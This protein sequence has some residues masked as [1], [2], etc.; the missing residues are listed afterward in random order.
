MLK[1]RQGTVRVGNELVSDWS[2][3][4]AYVIGDIVIDDDV[5][6]KCTAGHT[7]SQPPSANW[8]TFT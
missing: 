7:N 2:S 3:S 5:M 4:T 1:P 6:Y 8:S